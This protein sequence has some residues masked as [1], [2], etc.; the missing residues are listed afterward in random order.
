MPSVLVTG[1]NRGL[2]LEFVRQ[3]ARARWRVFAC[4][5]APEKA[6]DLQGLADDPELPVS[7]HRLDVSG[8]QTLVGLARD[9]DSEAIDVLINNA[10]IHPRQGDTL[11]GIGFDDWELC[12][13]VNTLGP[14]RVAQALLEHVARSD[15]R[16]MAM[17]TSMMGSMTCN[18]EGRSYEYRSS[19]AA[20]NA[21]V[22]N[23]AVEL[24]SRGI[25]VVALHPGWVNTD[26]GGP[27]API[28]PEVSIAGCRRVIEKL[29]PADSGKFLN[30]QGHEIEW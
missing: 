1:A 7:I 24:R 29:A 17:I 19:K 5:R 15:G 2:G 30:Y 20:L 25:V 18:A 10:G 11:D 4:C 16:V 13:R 9:L 12:L 26:M 23:L 28:G 6:V 14:T 3:Y 22:R 21:V 8:P 27:Q